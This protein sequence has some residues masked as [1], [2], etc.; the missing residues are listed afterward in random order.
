MHDAMI[1]IKRRR[2]ALGLTLLVAA[3]QVGANVSAHPVSV[4]P[5]AI[6]HVTTVANRCPTFSWAGMSESDAVILEIHEADEREPGNFASVRHSLP[7]LEVELPGGARSWT[8]AGDRCL[9]PGEMYAWS[10][11][12]SADNHVSDRSGMRHFRI[13]NDR[14]V[15]P[16]SAAEVAWAKD[17]LQRYLEQPTPTAALPEIADGKSAD[18][19][20]AAAGGSKADVSTQSATA[21]GAT[22][23]A[24]RVNGRLK[25]NQLRAVATPPDFAGDIV[26][27]GGISAPAGMMGPRITLTNRN[28]TTL[29]DEPLFT[30][31]ATGTG[32]AG[33]PVVVTACEAG[34]GCD[35]AQSPQAS[36]T[37]EA[38][39]LSTTTGAV[40]IVP[41]GL[42][43]L[44]SY[45]W[46]GSGGAGY[47]DIPSAFNVNVDS[48][49]SGC[50]GRPAVGV[51]LWETDGD[52]IGI[53][54]KCS[55]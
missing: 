16:P 23:P 37:V 25:A 31:R 28:P 21:A 53:Q 18:T 40:Y 2:I 13:R 52:Q 39:R 46:R 38:G 24:L 34:S 19:H 48:N 43:V 49:Y 9:V 4:S 27:E 51:R 33:N 6:D 8:P 1:L 50:S 10:V 55:Q 15:A 41:G 7:V 35:D 44:G 14:S 36:G 30:L 26:A 54:I 29:E 22:P 17:V 20:S 11:R 47:F 5:G 42:R 45:S 32:S 3:S 12:R